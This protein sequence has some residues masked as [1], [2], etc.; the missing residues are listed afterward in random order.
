MDLKR[1]MAF[2]LTTQSSYI[3]RCR[4]RLLPEV[5]QPAIGDRGQI[6]KGG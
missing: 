5:P 1:R 2:G 6:R 3:N 4:D